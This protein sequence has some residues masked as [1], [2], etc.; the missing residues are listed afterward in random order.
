MRAASENGGVLI[1]PESHTSGL[2]FG[3]TLDY[4]SFLTYAKPPRGDDAGTALPGPM[5]PSP[6]PMTSTADLSALPDIDGF[7]RVTRALAM[8]DA[9]LSPDWEFRYYSFNSR[10]GDGEMMASMR[11]G[12]G[13][14][15]FALICPAGVALH[16]LAHEAP[17]FT[18]D[19][20]HPAIF[21]SLPP[22]FKTNFHDEPAFV[23]ANST[24][25]IWRRAADDRW[26]CGAPPE[27]CA[28]D[29]S[30]DFLPILLGQPQHY[31]EFAADY[32]ER[33]LDLADVAAVY[34]HQPL[35]E[36]LV[37]RL[38]PDVSLDDLEDDID[39]IGYPDAP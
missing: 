32:Y 34:G 22:E 14:H 5:L 2:S 9:I 6:S 11:N 13:D 31:V 7:R 4:M 18:P 17:S 36:E 1:S 19:Q 23:T 10:W 25:C 20:P 12:E 26:H 3:D 15:W 33:Q 21:G 28:Q 30:E 37:G 27:L 39:E 38:N 24:Y 29:G 35:S 16:G 8:L